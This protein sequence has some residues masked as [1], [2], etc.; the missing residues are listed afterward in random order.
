[1]STS[2][3]VI[4]KIN[5]QIINGSNFICQQIDNIDF[6]DRGL[7]S[8][9]IV[10][11]LSSFVEYIALRAF[12]DFTAIKYHRDYVAS[13]MQYVKGRPRLRFLSKF[14]DFINIVT[15]QCSLEPESYE[16]IMLKYYEYLI[17]CKKMLL[18]NF[19]L[20]VLENLDK[21]PIST[22]TELREYYQKIAIKME[23]HFF[24]NNISATIVDRYYI[25]KIKPFFV[26]GEIYYEITFNI[27]SER[28][29][30]F[31]R[32]IAFTNKE[33]SAYY[34][35]KLYIVEEYIEIIDRTMA[36][37]IIIDWEISI[38][39]CELNNF[40]R[41]FGEDLATQ[42][43]GAEYRGLMKYLTDTGFNLVDIVNFSD[44]QYS[45][46]KE[47]IL[48]LY[49]AR[50]CYFLNI[51]D[52][53]RII[54]NNDSP[55][56][57]V[58]R[59]LLYHLE[60]KVIKNQINRNKNNKL[61]ELHLQYGCIPF[62]EMPFNSSLI[63]HNNRFLDLLECIKSDNRKHEIFAR[64]IRNNIENNCQLYT[65]I[66]DITAFENVDSLIHNYNRKIY[67]KQ[68]ERRKLVNR[69]NH[70]YI[71][72]YEIDTLEVIKTLTSLSDGGVQNYTNSV[73]AWMSTGKY[74]IDCDEKKE[75]LSQMFEKS[76]V[77][78]IYG[79]AGTG[80]STLINHASHFFAS[81]Q[82]LYL[83][84]T[85][86]AVDNLKRRVTASNS[87][88]MT[89]SKFLARI[90]V[91]TKYD[92]LIIDE[93]STVS[94]NDMCQIL[95]KA[96]FKLLILVGD[97]YQIESI[98]FGNWFSIIHGFLPETAVYEL[99]KPYRSDNKNLLELWK[100]VR[101]MDDT[102]LELMAKQKYSV[103]LNASI[104][105]PA[106]QDEIVLCLNYDGLYGINNINRF[107]QQSNPTQEVRWGVHIYKVGDPILF[108]DSNR[109][110]SSLIHNNSKGRIIDIFEITNRIRF[111][112][113]LD[114]VL[115]A[116]EANGEFELLDNS[117]NGNSVI[118]FF[119]DKHKGT[120]ED[121]DQMNTEI[122]PF[123]VAYAVSIHKAQGLEYNSVKIVISDEVDEL[124]TH[125]IFY[126][127]I[128]RSKESLKIYW[129]PE[130][131]RKVLN[132]LKPR[133]NKDDIDMIRLMLS[134]L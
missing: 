94:N 80:K 3:E 43:G 15:F 76:K 129:T 101:E 104:F 79:S 125:N 32:I 1:M 23:Q 13:A 123:Q 91:Q 21:F 20:S 28:A 119:V 67:Y 12:A 121:D 48:S 86:P 84:Q 106:S 18:S 126:T 110:S 82:K 64:Y 77:A 49:N 127:A 63:G 73:R 33:I 24:I 92:I 50:T 100:Q 31:D 53:C 45:K 118:R 111:D 112:I 113:E 46:V 8:Q 98:K 68:Q 62:D 69:N 134:N 109:F 54:I 5:K 6:L 2:A 72:E 103:P 27:A 81:N 29:N 65:S 71:N 59:Y 57:N 102:I 47:Y 9:N 74:Y 41:I 40:S 38:R 117:I 56:N 70:I 39:P 10:R 26:N 22:D 87:T 93:C 17:Q 116:F 108:N 36:V 130:V 120:D 89:I 75:V 55:G 132:R 34:A 97:I 107:L 25:K 7:A 11:S 131:E 96:D 83:A 78:L 14:H 37:M 90:N 95:E 115:N 4:T 44:K 99:V 114:I 60:N 105:A 124:I 16:R 30:K 122:M 58:L 51:L 42:S 88:Y 35:A 52:K 66:T 85:N 133:N 19:S 128:T 61:S